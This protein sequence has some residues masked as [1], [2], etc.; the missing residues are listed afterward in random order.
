MIAAR[1]PIGRMQV[2]RVP[3]SSGSHIEPALEPSWTLAEKL[4]WLLGV[5]AVD[6]GCFSISIYQH[7][8]DDER[9]AVST[10][11]Q[12][13]AYRGFEAVWDQVR[14]MEAGYALAKADAASGPAS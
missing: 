9:F 8:L 10:P 6:T 11:G 14:D 13:Y 2:R 12:G 7:Q 5:V 4:A 3:D 1:E